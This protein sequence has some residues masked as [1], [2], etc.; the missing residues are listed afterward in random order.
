[1]MKIYSFATENMKKH[2]TWRKEVLATDAAVRTLQVLKNE[3]HN[4]AE[5]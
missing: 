3:R 5:N 2:D 1:M 4:G